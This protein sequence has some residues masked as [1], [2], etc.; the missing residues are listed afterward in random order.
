MYNVRIYVSHS[1]M[2]NAFT[3]RLVK[4]LERL[5]ATVWVE[6]DPLSRTNFA[7]SIN[8]G[9][10]NCE[11]VLLIQTPEAL[12][13]DWVREEVEFASNLRVNRRIKE[14]I[15]V[16]AADCAGLPI[17]PMWE[18]LHN[19]DATQNYDLALDGL[20][21]ALKLVQSPLTTPNPQG[22]NQSPASD[23]PAD[24]FRDDHIEDPKVD[25]NDLPKYIGIALAAIVFIGIGWAYVDMK[26]NSGPPASS[27]A[28]KD[29]DRFTKLAAKVLEYRD[30][31]KS[32]P[33]FG[34]PWEFRSEI[35]TTI[36]DPEL[37]Q[38]LDSIK[39][40]KNLGD[41]NGKFISGDTWMFLWGNKDD[42]GICNMDG[43]C[44]LAEQNQLPG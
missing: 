12:R 41:T 3:M 11:W 5:G 39:V 15:P 31:H 6:Y 36:T 26:R 8:D 37:S 30:D 17:P 25:S 10:G 14:I 22:W 34:D 43:S 32:F 16:I 18:V 33:N 24:F 13:S 29:L 20:A 28:K 23:S 42:F 2:D 40:N 9:L 19:Y 38:S 44:R 27:Q 21:R 1:R 35:R 7:K 4:D